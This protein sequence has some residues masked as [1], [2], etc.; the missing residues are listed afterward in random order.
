METTSETTTANRHLR[1]DS[2]HPEVL[3]HQRPM[4]EEEAG[5]SHI[6]RSWIFCP[7]VAGWWRVWW[8]WRRRWGQNKQKSGELGRVD[9]PAGFF[10]FP[11]FGIETLTPRF[12]LQTAS[13]IQFCYFQEDDEPMLPSELPDGTA[14]EPS[15]S[16][17]PPLP[18]G[19]AWGLC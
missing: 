11:S 2:K 3:P 4:E 8:I 10:W 5:R 14:V 12:G 13:T 16:S 19:W 6:L 1:Y 7:N 15:S 18:P 9:G 17:T